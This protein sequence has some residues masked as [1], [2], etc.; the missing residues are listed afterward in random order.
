MAYRLGKSGWVSTRF[1][2][3]AGPPLDTIKRWVMESY[4]AKRPSRCFGG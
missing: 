4:R 3:A 1:A 2:S